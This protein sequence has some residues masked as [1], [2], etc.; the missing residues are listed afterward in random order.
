MFFIRKL[1]V[2]F[3]A[4]L[5][6]II[7]ILIANLIEGKDGYIFK[8]I[9]PQASSYTCLS[10][11]SS[12]TRVAFASD[13]DAS[14]KRESSRLHRISISETPLRD[15]VTPFPLRPF[16]PY[17]GR[18]STVACVAAD[19]ILETYPTPLPSSLSLPPKQS[20]KRRKSSISRKSKA[21][22]MRTIGGLRVITRENI[23]S[24]SALLLPPTLSA[25][26]ASAQYNASLLSSFLYQRLAIRRYIRPIRSAVL[27]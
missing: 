8:I 5:R 12:I 11:R 23:A 10:K 2:K 7:E 1:N 14:K 25:S 6:G 3:P 17:R 15:E 19:V 27:S 18:R 4:P 20:T 16:H 26:L 21:E 22:S 24:T 13:F 9:I